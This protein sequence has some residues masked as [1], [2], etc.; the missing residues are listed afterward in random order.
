MDCNYKDGLRKK[1][2]E[3]KAVNTSEKVNLLEGE[4]IS[5]TMKRK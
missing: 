1:C 2:I 3:W 5:E 4:I